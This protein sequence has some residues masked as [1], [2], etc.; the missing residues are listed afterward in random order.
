MD[1]RGAIVQENVRAL[2]LGWVWTALNR[3]KQEPS[4]HSLREVPITMHEL[5]A[6]RA[7]TADK[8]VTV[9]CPY[10]GGCVLLAVLETFHKA[11]DLCWASLVANDCGI[12][13]I[14]HPWVATVLS[15]PWCLAGTQETDLPRAP[16]GNHPRG[17]LGQGAARLWTQLCLW[18][19]SP[20]RLSGVGSGCG[21]PG[22]PHD[23]AWA[24]PRVGNT[25][26]PY[27]EQCV[28]LRPSPL[29]AN[30]AWE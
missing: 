9:G 22:A 10:G 29:R 14:V 28:T 12:L 19:T 20:Q 17:M 24:G 23:V 7:A 16:E 30:D 15:S 25:S 3:S 4:E 18:H 8:E 2:W 13:A 26:A 5:P 6:A 11:N 21:R 27:D 1:I